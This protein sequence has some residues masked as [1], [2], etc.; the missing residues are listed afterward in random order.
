M[1]SSRR[2]ALEALA[3][4]YY[5]GPT[6]PIYQY[7]CAGCQKKVDVFF[8]SV[9]AAQEKQAV[10]PQC[11]GEQLTRVMSTFA[12]N[13]SLMERLDGVD[14][15]REASKLMGNDPGTFV[16][17]AK[18]AGREWDEELG[19]NWEELA[20]RTLAGEDPAERIDAD[21]TFRYHIEEKK[22]A[23]EQAM[24]PGASD[25]PGFDDP[26]APY[27][28]RPVQDTSTDSASSG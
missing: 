1:G 8:R 17:W 16:D 14:H 15:V 22:Y 23:L 11:G 10:C 25:D 18:R 5:T 7:N 12:R 28:N 4:T 20:E 19:T 21:Y 3:G 13:R 27:F 24:N 2:P 6:M 26:Y 9:A